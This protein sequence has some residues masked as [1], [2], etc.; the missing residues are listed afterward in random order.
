MVAQIT[1]GRV[2]LTIMALGLEVGVWVADYNHTHIFNPRWPPHAKFHNGQTMSMGMLLGLATLYY[3]W[4]ED[5]TPKS[6]AKDGREGDSVRVAT[7]FAS[8]YYVAGLAAWFFPGALAV[9]PEFG[10]GFPQ[11]YIFGSQLL[12]VW[13]GCWLEMSR[14]SRIAADNTALRSKKI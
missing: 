11:L 3:T 4:R 6:G 10:E 14:L 2:I 8:L 12:V 9:D 5:P 1:P 7:I 13:F